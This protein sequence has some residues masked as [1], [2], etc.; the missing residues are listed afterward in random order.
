[1][2][3]EDRFEFIASR[4]EQVKHAQ[5]ERGCLEYRLCFDAFEPGRITLDERWRTMADLQEHI[6]LV[7]ARRAEDGPEKISYTR[8]VLLLEGEPTAH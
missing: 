2:A 8:T 1:M 6:K 5:A 3:P 4:E 7:E